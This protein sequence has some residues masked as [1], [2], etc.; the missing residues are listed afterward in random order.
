MEKVFFSD[1]KMVGLFFDT[2]TADENH[3][4]LNR[5]NLTS[6]IQML[7][8]RKQKTF[9]EVCLAFFKSLLIFKN[10]QKKDDS[11]S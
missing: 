8:S 11:H 9:S 5:D 3:F 6:P 2:L 4:L 10:L 1:I 7:L